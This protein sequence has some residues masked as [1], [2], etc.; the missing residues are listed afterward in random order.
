MPSKQLVYNWY[1]ALVAAGCMILMGYD[2]SVFN[3][4]QVSPNWKAHFNTPNAHMIGL[5]NTTYTVGGIVTGWF[6]SGPIAD[7]FGRRWGMG[8]GCM[9]T[10][11][12]TFIQTFTPWHQIGVFIFGRILIGVGQAVAITS[13]PIY[14][15]EITESHIRGKVMSFWQMF[16]SVGS[17]IAYWINYGAAQRRQTLG[18]W[19]WKMVVIFQ[20]MM[21][22]II[23]AQLPFIP[24]SPRWLISRRKDVEGARKALARVRSE[25]DKVE[26][27]I[28]AIRE[29]IEYEKE[30]QSEG[31]KAYLA[32]FKDPSIRKRLYITF[33]INVGQQLSGQGTLNS[34][35]STIYAKVFKDSNTINL[36]NA[37]NATFGILFTLNAV[38]TVD[39]YGRKFLF[40]VGA[41]GMAMC[42]MLIPV[43]GLTTPGTQEKSQPVGI[44]ITFLA[45]LF[46]FFYKPTWGATT[47]TYTSEVFP[48]NVRGP[49]VGMS[50]Q[51]Q[52]VANTI[53]QQF[54][55]IFYQNEG[56][57]TFFFFMTTNVCLACVVYFIL[58][59]TKQ[60]PLEEMDALF[61]G[62]NHVEKG[63]AIFHEADAQNETAAHVVSSEN[64]KG[65]DIEMVEGNERRV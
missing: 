22:V 35:S 36:I 14:I 54:F 6:F 4:V 5:I 19:D 43:V 41:C 29:A 49:A 10:V 50:V 31:W 1:V 55:P 65:Q 52:G 32:L 21:P 3:S 53:F 58:P 8:I 7:Y 13:G 27:E 57:K 24:E 44:A 56:L 40:L 28:R 15:G 47:W 2:A 64:N 26:E 62:V 37:L 9:I 59:E 61:G 18:D 38:W 25:T 60:V 34:Y 46:A 20:L 45:F 23:I 42:T 30:A 39:R 17:F 16:Y 33:F 51:M 11:V 48:L 63:A 12:A